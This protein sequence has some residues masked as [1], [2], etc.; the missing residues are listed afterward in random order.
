MCSAENGSG[1]DRWE[2]R[3]TTGAEAHIV[4]VDLPTKGARTLHNRTAGVLVWLSLAGLV[5]AVFSALRF[6]PLDAS[7]RR[8]SLLREKENCIWRAYWSRGAPA[9]SALTA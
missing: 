2:R 9:S 4:Y 1:W 7:E 5:V 3:D 8:P 6:R